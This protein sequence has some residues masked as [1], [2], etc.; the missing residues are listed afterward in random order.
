MLG[1]ELGW[2]KI[3]YTSIYMGQVLKIV[4]TVLMEG[5]LHVLFC[6]VLNLETSK[7]TIE[8]MNE[9]IKVGPDEEIM[10]WIVGKADQLTGLS[11]KKGWGIHAKHAVF[12]TF[13]FGPGSLGCLNQRSKLWWSIQRRQISEGHRDI[14]PLRVFDMEPVASEFFF[15]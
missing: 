6:V 13:F 12:N 8:P 7:A 5:S 1:H 11:T 14:F 4:G 9:K 10:V 3:I 15:S 2:L